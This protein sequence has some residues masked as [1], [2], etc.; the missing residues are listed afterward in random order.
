[1]MFNHATLAGIL[2]NTNFRFLLTQLLAVSML[3]NGDY[4]N[5]WIQ[6][7]PSNFMSTEAMMLSRQE[8]YKTGELTLTQGKTEFYG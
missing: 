4:Q 1:M 7:I 3:I 2:S 8:F 5:G 6:M